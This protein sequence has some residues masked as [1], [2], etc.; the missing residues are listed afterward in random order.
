MDKHYYDISAKELE[1]QLKTSRGGLTSAEAKKRLEQYGE[2]VLP[3]KKK[4][5]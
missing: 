2:N 4:A 1:T 5:L 3:K